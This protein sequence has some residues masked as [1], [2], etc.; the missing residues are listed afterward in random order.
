MTAMDLIDGPVVNMYAVRHSPHNP[1][2]SS[3]VVQDLLIHDIDLA[4]RAA[5]TDDLPEVR[6]ALWTP[7]ASDRTEVAEC[8]LRFGSGAVANL[9]A[10]RW[11]QRKVREVQVVTDHQLIEVDLLRQSVT[12]YRN[13]SQALVEGGGPY[14]AETVVDVPYVRHR[15]EPLALQLAAFVDLVAEND[16]AAIATE[17]DTILPPHVVAAVMDSL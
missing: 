2:V 14:R 6:G 15:G 13:I 17:R 3:S 9:S 1:F 8:V 12:V 5:T 4:M 10:S 7:P 16:A 11:S